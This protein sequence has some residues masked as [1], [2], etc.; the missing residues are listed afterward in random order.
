VA[1]LELDFTKI[2]ISE[3]N[4]MSCPNGQL[5]RHGAHR[6]GHSRKA[7]TKSDGT[8]IKATHVKPSYMSRTCITDVGA[9]GYGPKRLP[10]IKNSGQLRSVG[11][12]TH[13]SV[14]QRR[15]SLKKASKKYGTLP[16]LRRLNLAHNYQKV[17][18]PEAYKKM[19]E[20]VKFL[21]REYA[22]Q[23]KKTKSKK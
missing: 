12:S 11:Y 1:V 19:D 3:Y 23:K 20:D 9:P 21:S 15:A 18:N 6:K 4:I 10:S 7:Y 17:S 2:N 22:K 16:V 14:A 8:K 13:K 5:M